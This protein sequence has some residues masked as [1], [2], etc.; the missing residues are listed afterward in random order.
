MLEGAL[1]R[2]FT[3]ALL[4]CLSDCDR[5]QVMLEGALRPWGHNRRPVRPPNRDRKQVM[6]EGALRPSPARRP[7]EPSA[8]KKAQKRDPSPSSRR[9]DAGRCGGAM[10]RGVARRATK[11]AQKR[12]ASP[13]L[14]SWIAHPPGLSRGGDDA[15][16]AQHD[17]V[18]GRLR[19]AFWG[20]KRRAPPPPLD[21]QHSDAS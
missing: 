13:S 3:S 7:G 20:I 21:T 14:T 15:S 17:D 1:R 16:V 12:D 11:K 19:T 10:G 8:T 2:A 5:K 6:L 4:Y 18:A 9:W